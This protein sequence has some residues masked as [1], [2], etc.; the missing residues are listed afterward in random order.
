VIARRSV[1]GAAAL[2]GT[3]PLRHAGAQAPAYPTRAVRVIVALGAGGDAD[4]ITR[5]VTQRMAELL[6]QPVVVE[7][8][9]GAGSIVGHEAVARAAPDGYTLIMGSITALT[10]NVALYPRLPYDPVADFT[11][12][13]FIASTPG[14]LVV[15]AASPW[16]TPADIIAAARM[17]PGALSFA[18]AGNGNL[19]H[20]MAEVFRR[21][22]DIDVLHV[23]YRVVTDAQRDVAAGRVAFM[24]AVAPS[25]LPLIQAGQ[26]KPIAVTAAARLPQLPAVPTMTELG[27]SGFEMSSWFGLM[28]PRGTPPE[29][30]ATLNAAANDALRT[31]A[32]AER[33]AQ[34][35]VTPGGGT[36]AEFAAFVARERARWV[37]VVRD[38]GIRLE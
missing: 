14:I 28:A 33:L 24:F 27:F 4:L 29:V 25:T 21:G 17:R 3:M 38:A 12:I 7:N 11:P 5:L 15:P 9:P 18:S 20:L 8:R 34:M 30:I 35:S 31:P 26:L 1:L 2:L 13:V 32:V 10:A 6:G 36:P 19:T 37:G 23:P 16:T 22:T